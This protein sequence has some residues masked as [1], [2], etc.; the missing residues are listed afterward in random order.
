MLG[1]AS[2]RTL[3]LSLIHTAGVIHYQHHIQ[4]IGRGSRSLHI[5]APDVQSNVH[6]SGFLIILCCL[7]GFDLTGLELSSSRH[8]FRRGERRNRQQCQHHAQHHER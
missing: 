2:G 4:C 1:I 7:P 6:I 5:F 3:A 8:R